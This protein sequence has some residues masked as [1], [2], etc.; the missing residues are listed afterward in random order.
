MAPLGAATMAQLSDLPSGPVLRIIDHLIRPP[1]PPHDRRVNEPDHHELDYKQIPPLQR[2]QRPRR[3]PEPRYDDAYWYRDPPAPPPGASFPDGLPDNPLLPASLIN[4]TFRRCA[5]EVLFRDVELQ[6]PWEA[7]MFLRS[8]TS[9]DKPAPTRGEP[10]LLKNNI[11][12]EPSQTRKLGQHVRSIQFLWGGPCSLGKGGGSLIYQ[13]LQSCPK[14]EKIAISTTLLVRCKEPVLDALGSRPLVKEFVILKNPVKGI[15]GWLANDVATQLLPNWNH[16]ETIDFSRL[17]SRYEDRNKPIPQPI[18]VINCALRKVVLIQ[19]N[20]YGEQ[21]SL[22]L[23]SS[24]E[25]MQTLKIVDPQSHLDRAGLCQVLR[26]C[27]GPKLESLTLEI[28]IRMNMDWD[29]IHYQ[30][31]IKGSD[32]PSKNRDLLDIVFRTS[33]AMSNLKS[34]TFAGSLASSDLFSLLPP[35]IVKLAWERC[36][37]TGAAFAAALSSYQRC[38][39]DQDLDDPSGPAR[40]VQLLP[41]LKCCS[42]R[43]AHNWEGDYKQAIQASFRARGACYHSKKH[44]S[45]C[46]DYDEG[47]PIGLDD[48]CGSDQGDDYGCAGCAPSDSDDSDDGQFYENQ[49]DYM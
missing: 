8:L 37:I 22:I 11:E 15:P 24:R 20:V 2:Q 25:S 36:H 26:D 28:N 23:K 39:S 34:L 17:C 1:S 30:D 49:Y 38:P 12:F 44:P 43:H 21:L 31:H 6:S 3:Y 48:G 33:D 18:P 45:W 19:P 14:L 41:N 32:D 46:P 9:A 40:Q 35:S 10:K 4:C 5:Q 7:M 42:V 13:I 16:L 29:Q 27:A 47:E